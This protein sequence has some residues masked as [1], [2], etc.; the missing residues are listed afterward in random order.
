M[1]DYNT[2]NQRVEQNDPNGS[3]LKIVKPDLLCGGMHQFSILRPTVIIDSHMHIQSGRCAP[4]RLVQQL[5]GVPLRRTNIDRTG[6]VGGYLMEF[7]GIIVPIMWLWRAPFK[8][9]TVRALS[10]QGAKSTLECG[11]DFIKDRKKTIEEFF[12]EDNLY[13]GLSNLI[14][15]GVVMTMDMEYAHVDGYYGLKIYNALYKAKNDIDEMKPCA[16]WS[17]AHGKWEEWIDYNT[18]SITYGQK[19]PFFNETKSR[20]EKQYT[21]TDV[22][23]KPTYPE[24]YNEEYKDKFSKEG[25]IIGTYFD[26]KTNKTMQVEVNAVPVELPEHETDT[27]EQWEKQL[28]DTELTVLKYPLKFLP[29]FHY[30]PRRWQTYGKNGNDYPM[31]QVTGAGLHLGFKM[32]TAQGYRPLDPRLPIMED[33][34]A[35]C[36]DNRIPIM[37]HGTPGGAASFEKKEFLNFRHFNDS[38][39]DTNLQQGDPEAYFNKYFVSPDAWEEVLKKAIKLNEVKPGFCRNDGSISEETVVS[40]TV[41]LNELHL[42]LAHFG[43][44][45]DLGMEWNEKIIGMINGGDYPNLYTDISS[46]FA[47]KEFRES[48]KEIITDKKN[49]SLKERILFGTDWYMTFLY[50]TMVGMNFK[51]YCQTAKEFLDKFDTSLWPKFTQH[52]PYRFYRINEQIDRIAGNII[53]RRNTEKVLKALDLE[54]DEDIEI[55]EKEAAYIKVA[56]EDYLQIWET[57][58]ICKV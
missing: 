56:N 10:E 22:E 7:F 12:M 5:S 46:S 58:K 47:N 11:D 51:E 21:R 15:S 28:R 25:S 55:I 40:K 1:A 54:I 4:L 23:G 8:K 32:Y 29:M 19:I 27:Y 26:S 43:G 33:F 38:L 45:T 2:T 17:P 42:C 49:E 3:I 35:R 37:N 53:A 52:N 9:S 36:C 24:L 30:D 44:P 31:S 6:K 18:E 20:D 48:F 14:V 41:Y 39:E 57:P 13:K 50:S 34:Y 16:Y